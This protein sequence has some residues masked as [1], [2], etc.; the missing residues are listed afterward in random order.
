MALDVDRLA[1]DLLSPEIEHGVQQD[2]WRLEGRDGTRVYV[3]LVASD[4]APYLLEL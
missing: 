2:F 4:G 3:R 1:A